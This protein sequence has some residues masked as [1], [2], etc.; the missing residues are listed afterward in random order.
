MKKKNIEGTSYASGTIILMITRYCIKEE[1]EPFET[2]TEATGEKERG[3][4]V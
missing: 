4:H 1:E 3:P 2:T